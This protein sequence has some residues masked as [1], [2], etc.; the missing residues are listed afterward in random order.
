MRTQPHACLDE[1]PADQWNGLVE[2]GYPFLRHEFL[3]ALEHHGAVGRGFGWLPHHLVCR[4]D[5]GVLTGA[6]PLYLKDNSYGEFV[7]DWAWAD[8]CER[9]GMPYYPKLVAA[10]PYTP[11]PGPR[12]LT[13]PGHH[14]TTG[15]ALAEAALAEARRLGVSSLHWLFPSAA[16]DALLAQQGL[17]LR[18][19]CQFHW[20]N[21]G[22][23]DF[24]DFLSTFNSERRKKVR[25]ER[26]RVAE[27]NVEIRI[28]HGHETQPGDWATFH[29]FYVA[30]F[31]RHGGVPTLSQGFFAEVAHTL[32]DRVVLVLAAC[33]GRDVAG[34]LCFRSDDTLYGRHWGCDETYDGLHF[35]ACYYQGIEYCI[36]H[37][38]RHFQPGAQGEH[39][40]WRGFEPTAT[41]SMHW[42]AH[43]EFRR[44]IARF[45]EHERR[46]MTYYIDEMRAHTPFKAAP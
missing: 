13:K 29:R 24:D 28:L 25:R 17:L 35:E 14:A 44:G 3:S 36:R 23:R 15:L 6:A 38:L 39:K 20:R 41:T 33:G 30:T 21:P 34:A 18:T 22:Y 16:D 46:E 37:G 10:I 7:F 45:L 5:D 32:G 4:D 26:R 42:I 1:I 12:M 19:G 31:Q 2:G 40:I 27:Q 43:P 11:A 8:A 9:A